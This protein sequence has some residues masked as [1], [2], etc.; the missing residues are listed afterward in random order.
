[1]PVLA[2]SALAAS[3]RLAALPCSTSRHYQQVAVGQLI[4]LGDER[5]LQP[6]TFARVPLGEVGSAVTAGDTVRRFQR[7]LA[8]Y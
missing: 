8:S 7:P 5:M 3:A 4:E 1:M 6:G 2:S